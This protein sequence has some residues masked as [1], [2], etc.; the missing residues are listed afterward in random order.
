MWMKYILLLTISFFGI[1]LG[2]DLYV[3]NFSDDS[4][5]LG[6]IFLCFGIYGTFRSP[7]SLIEAVRSLNDVEKE[8][9]RFNMMMRENKRIL[10][11]LKRRKKNDK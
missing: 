11:E 7:I 9:E 5:L 1:Y 3:E 10:C 4:I 6:T 8:E 2:I